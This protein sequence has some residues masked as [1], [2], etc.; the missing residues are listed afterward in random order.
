MKTY[1]KAEFSE[2]EYLNLRSWVNVEMHST[3]EINLVISLRLVGHITFLNG[4]NWPSWWS[5]FTLWWFELHQRT[6]TI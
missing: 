4:R 5:R 3:V 1:K 6:T 2:T